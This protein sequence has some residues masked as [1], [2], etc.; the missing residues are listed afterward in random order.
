[1][2]G[3]LAISG[4]TQKNVWFPILSLEASFPHKNIYLKKNKY[5]YKNLTFRT[6]TNIPARFIGECF[7]KSKKFKLQQP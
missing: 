1:M 4:N 7:L 3:K 2:I 5:K 6:P